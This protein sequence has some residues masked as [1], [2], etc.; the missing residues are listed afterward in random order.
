MKVERLDIHWRQACE[1]TLARD[2][3]VELVRARK[4]PSLVSEVPLHCD[5][6]RG[7]KARKDLQ[8]GCVGTW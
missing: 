7:K 3:A 2:G 4:H 5:M 1:P 8:E 6:Q